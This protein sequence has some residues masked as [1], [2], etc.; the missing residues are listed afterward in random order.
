M[1]PI[2]IENSGVTVGFSGLLPIYN[3]NIFV[4]FD[5]ELMKQNLDCEID[6]GEANAICFCYLN[7]IYICIPKISA[8]SIAHESMHALFEVCNI[9]DIEFDYE[10]QEPTAYLAGTINQFVADCC[11]EIEDLEEQS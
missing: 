2:A 7:D 5:F 3:I 6:L 9:A 11:F 1:K 4:F 10:N 8:N